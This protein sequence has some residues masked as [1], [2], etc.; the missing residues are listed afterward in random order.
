[1][2]G[3]AKPQSGMFLSSLIYAAII[4]TN[5]CNH[6]FVWWKKSLIVYWSLAQLLQYIHYI[7]TIYYNIIAFP[8]LNWLNWT[9]WLLWSEAS[10]RLTGTN[11]YQRTPLWASK[12]NKIGWT[13]ILPNPFTE[14]SSILSS[15][16]RRRNQVVDNCLVQSKPPRLLGRGEDQARARNKTISQRSAG[17]AQ[18]PVFLLLCQS[19]AGWGGQGGGRAEVAA[20][21]QLLLLLLLSSGADILASKTAWRVLVN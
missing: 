21:S 12:V 18:L 8:L 1:M 2:T 19:G 10:S 13:S 6:D 7:Y 20:H 5:G 4:R 15:T 17:A 16:G 14:F 9:D 11:P 3:S